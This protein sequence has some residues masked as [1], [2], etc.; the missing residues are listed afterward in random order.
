MKPPSREARKIAQP[1]TGQ[2]PAYAGIKPKRFLVKD[3]VRIEVDENNKPIDP[4][5]VPSSY[6]SLLKIDNRLYPVDTRPLKINY[7]ALHSPA[8]LSPNSQRALS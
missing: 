5:A 8:S 6:P 7:T 1:I 2:P 4:F 3:G